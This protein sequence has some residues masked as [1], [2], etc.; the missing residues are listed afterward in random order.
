M[1]RF[2]Y[3]ASAARQ[4]LSLVLPTEIILI[5]NFLPFAEIARTNFVIGPLRQLAPETYLNESY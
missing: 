3:S 5:F 4:L 1:I 2:E